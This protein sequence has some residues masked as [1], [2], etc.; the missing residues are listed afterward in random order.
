MRKVKVF[1][2][3]IADLLLCVNDR[4]DLFSKA[5]RK[6]MG[7]YEHISMYI[8]TFHYIPMLYESDGRGVVIQNIAH[9]TNRQV[10]VMR[11]ELE[12][13]D[14]HS[15]VTT[16]INIASKGKSHY[17]YLSLMH[18]AIPR[19]I[20]EKFPFIPIPSHYIRDDM[21]ICSEA[22]AEPFWRNN[23]IILPKN[24]IPLPSDFFISPILKH[25]YE[26][27]LLKDII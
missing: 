3:E 11:P 6:M 17:D 12:F 26:G 22:C 4:T 23:I 5:K 9:Q 25:V 14:K 27:K 7:R 13:R 15:I 10:V 16:A 21:M 19:V 1:E 18:S 8:G 2:L 20:K 24:I